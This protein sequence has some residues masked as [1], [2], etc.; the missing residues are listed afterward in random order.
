MHPNEI[1]IYAGIVGL[2]LDISEF[3]LGNGIAIRPTYAHVFS[4]SMIAFSPPPN[5]KSH[6]PGPWRAINHN[7]GYD[8]TAELFLHSEIQ[9]TNFDRWNTI[10]WVASLIRLLTGTAIRI[11][12]LSSASFSEG[13]TD[14]K[15]MQFWPIE[16]Q[17]SRFVAPTTKISESQLNWLKKHFQ[18]S[19]P[20]MESENFNRAFQIFDN[21]LWA[22]SL[23]SAIL[24]IWAALETLMRP[25]RQ[26]TGKTLAQLLATFLYDEKTKRDR[27]FG[28]IRNA[29]HARGKVAHN[30]ELP[31]LDEFT[32]VLELGQAVFKKCIE[33]NAQP[34]P[35]YLLENWKIADAK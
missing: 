16:M 19:A 22:Q 31:E 34:M 27:M 18:D 12:V 4:S 6:H 5:P 33:Q 7:F 15:E 1:N 11:P 29:Y 24:M 28:K 14:K 13:K 30:S 25:G 10:W 32:F 3:Q 21:A 20:L 23:G 35:D 17:H 2:Q 26:E 8:I 9:P